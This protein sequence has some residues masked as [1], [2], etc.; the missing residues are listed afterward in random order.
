MNVAR[1]H[2]I[3]LLM[4]ALP[5][6]SLANAAAPCVRDGEPSPAQETIVDAHAQHGSG[7][8][9]AHDQTRDTQDG[10]SALI[11]CPCCDHCVTVRVMSG[12]GL[13][14]FNADSGD[15]EHGNSTQPASVPEATD[16][17]DHDAHEH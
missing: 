17:H 10:E 14:A 15:H 6:S 16:E 2:V 12:C 13:A 1:K 8:H 7:H 4:M 9:G 5:L 11:G 3:W